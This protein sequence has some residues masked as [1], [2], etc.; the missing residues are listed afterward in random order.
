MKKSP[1]WNKVSN[2]LLNT[3][4]IY[5]FSWFC[6]VFWLCCA[7]F[8]YYRLVSSNSFTPESC[9]QL[10]LKNLFEC[11]VTDKMLQCLWTTLLIFGRDQLYVNTSGIFVS[12]E[13]VLSLFSK[14]S[15]L[16]IFFL[17]ILCL[18]LAVVVNVTDKP[19]FELLTILIKVIWCS[20]DPFDST[21]L[22]IQNTIF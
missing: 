2:Y 21:R 22:T 6:Y 1:A 9:Y 5:L 16:S 4:S 17:L 8:C 15:F 11:F 13:V 14:S 3:G 18:F 10:I 12:F 7:R 20:A 19:L